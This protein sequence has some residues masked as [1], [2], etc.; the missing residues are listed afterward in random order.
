MRLEWEKYFPRSVDDPRT[1]EQ[2][3]WDYIYNQGGFD[4]TD[5]IGIAGGVSKMA[6]GGIMNLKKK[7]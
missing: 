6:T 4:L 5:K 1:T 3:K 7:W 2:Q